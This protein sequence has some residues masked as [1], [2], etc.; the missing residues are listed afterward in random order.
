MLLSLPQHCHVQSSS[1]SS[2]E[3]RGSSDPRNLSTVTLLSVRPTAK[4]SSE[5]VIPPPTQRR[6]AQNSRVWRAV[7]GFLKHNLMQH[8]WEICSL[9]RFLL[10]S[11]SSVTRGQSRR[12]RRGRGYACVRASMHAWARERQREWKR[13]YQR[14]WILLCYS[15][16]LVFS[17]VVVNA[18][19]PRGEVHIHA[20]SFTRVLPTWV[21][22]IFYLVKKKGNSVR[23]RE[24]DIDKVRDVKNCN[25]K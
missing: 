19:C 18:R 22:A 4:E 16:E 13:D 11:C 14:I 10:P 6:N 3:R 23:V 15:L 21:E 2:R 20:Q 9:I 7:T 8:Q 24:K 5:I 25:K 17:G 12:V 1:E